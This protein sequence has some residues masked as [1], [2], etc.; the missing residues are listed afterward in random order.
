MFVAQADFDFPRTRTPAWLLRDVQEGA[1]VED[2]THVE[3]NHAYDNF[4]ITPDMVWDL[5]VRHGGGDWDLPL[6][7]YRVTFYSNANTR[8]DYMYQY[9]VDAATGFIEMCGC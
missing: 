2:G 6:Y 8:R 4:G 3:L 1:D 9:L 7:K 5:K